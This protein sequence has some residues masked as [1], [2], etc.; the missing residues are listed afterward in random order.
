TENT[1]RV[2]RNTFQDFLAFAPYATA[3]LGT[4]FI[5]LAID[6]DFGRSSAAAAGVLASAGINFVSEPIYA[7]LET[8]DFTPYLQQVLASGADAVLPIWAGDSSVTLF[9]QLDELGVGDQMA[10]V[11]A[12]NSNDI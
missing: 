12:F 3:E 4:D 7:P 10:V 1:F 9:Q 11:S 2:C 6:N 8:T 5:I